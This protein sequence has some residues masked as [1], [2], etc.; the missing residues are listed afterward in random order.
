MNDQD[1]A[2]GRRA[3]G[4]TVAVWRPLAMSA[5]EVNDSEDDPQAP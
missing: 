2:E 3:C 1:L 5:M 4:Q